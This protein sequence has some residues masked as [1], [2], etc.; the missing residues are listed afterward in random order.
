MTTGV[1][2]EIASRREWRRAAAFLAAAGVAA[3]I[4]AGCGEGDDPAR[5]EGSGSTFARPAFDGWCAGSD[6]CT[7]RA[8]GSG[9][10]VAEVIDQTTEFGASDVPLTA[11]EATELS[12]TSGDVAPEGSAPVQVPVLIGAVSVATNVAGADERR[13]RFSAATLA[14]VFAGEITRWADRRIAAENPGARLPDSPIVRCVRKDSSGTTAVF[15]QFLSQEDAAFRAAVGTSKLPDWPGSRVERFPGN[16]GVGAC[17]RDR[18][19][20]I[21][22]I[23]LADG[24][25][26]L[27]D[28][29]PPEKVRQLAEIGVERGGATE[30]VAP[31][32]ATTALAGTV[33]LDAGAPLTSYGAR[34]LNAPVKGAYPIVATSYLIVHDRYAQARTCDEVVRTARWAL[35]AR[36]QEE[37]S[38][39]YYAPLGPAVR[40]R[41][42]AQ[43]ARIR[44]ADGN[45]CATR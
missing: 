33:P 11:D 5:A 43:V 17:L 32:P 13:L 15:T 39:S 28:G 7:Y 21:G 18:D 26:L 22:Y 40:S 44:D 36:G 16:E 10:G 34:L 29:S 24:V 9:A 23:D 19:D 8:V 2:S 31:T 37:L 6:L 41:A 35:S 38:A 27:G 25:A 30:W 12:R 42:L 1:L 3:G 14:G 4:L 20:A 45:A